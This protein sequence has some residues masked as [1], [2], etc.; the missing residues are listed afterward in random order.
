MLTRTLLLTTALAGGLAT[1]AAAQTVTLRELFNLDR[2]ATIGGQFAISALRGVA[3]VTYTH[4]SIRPLSGHMVLT[5]VELSPYE[6]PDCIVTI[7]RVTFRTAPLDQIA[8]GALD[9]DLMGYEMAQACLSRGEQRDL[10]AL[11]ITDLVLDRGE[12]RVEYD[13][14]SAGML[15]DFHAVSGDLAEI[16]G[17]VA[18]DYAALNLDREEPVLDLAYA[19][20]ELTDRGM[21]P[22][23]AAMIP[24]AMLDPVSL[25]EMLAAEMLDTEGEMTETAP[26]APLP[27]DGK[28]PD[29][30]APAPAPEPQGNQM[31][32]GAAA[33]YAVLE[34]G[35]Q[36]FARFAANPSLLRLELTPER[37]VRLTEDHFEDFTLFVADLNPALFTE[38]DR[39]ETR[40][41]LAD[42]AVIEEWIGGGAV[43]IGTAD[44]MRYAHA[45]L[46]GVGAPRDPETAMDLLTPLLEAGDPDALDMALGTLDAID[47]DFAYLIARNAAAGGDRRAFSH[48]DRLEALLPMGEVIELQEDD[49]DRPVYTGSE[50][51]RTLRER[52]NASFTG[53]GA[54]RR[55]SFAYFYALLALASGDSAAGLIVDEIDA[56]GDR[57]PEEDAAHWAAFLGDVRD[58]AL[59]VWFT[60]D[61]E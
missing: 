49:P 5:G 59:E 61:P 41:T 16:R 13:Y 34:A 19:E 57:M 32:E 52:A 50:P 23:L 8:F 3:D 44:L 2:L 37:P 46:S 35:A 60:P 14:A 11:G 4:L 9:V 51:A 26:V 47:P 10:A 31:S 39:P 56:M 48:L 30:T 45:F 20:L 6:M 58:H 36:T 27:E 7:D 12:I 38:D 17:H 55:Y 1:Q 54:P 42:A 53:L 21:W 24:P 29:E 28:G 40:L 25:T 43:E 33:A 18:F 22:V 15:V